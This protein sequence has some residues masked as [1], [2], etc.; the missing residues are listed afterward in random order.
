MCDNEKVKQAMNKA[1]TVF[2]AVSLCLL[3]A[4]TWAVQPA[5]NRGGATRIQVT[6]GS[7][8]SRPTPVKVTPAPMSSA[9]LEMHVL[10]TG[11]PPN[12]NNL[13]SIVYNGYRRSS[14]EPCGC[15][16][17]KLGG[18]DREATI[19]EA[20]TSAG[21]PMIKLDAGGYV[22]DLAAQSPTFR[23]ATKYLLGALAALDY[24]VFNVGATDIEIGRQF[25][26]NSLGA[27]KDRLISA[28]I[29]DLATSSPLFAPYRILDV[30]LRNGETVKIGVTGITRPRITIATFE[31][32]PKGYV[33]T[34][35][36]VALRKVLPELDKKCDIVILLAYL[37]REA[38]TNDVLSKLGEDAKVDIA[39]AGEFSGL[40]NA[41]ENASG[42]RLVTGGFEGRQI[43]HL[44][45]DIRNGKIAQDFLKMVEIEQTISPRPDISKFITNY[46]LELVKNDAGTSTPDP[47]LR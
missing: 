40:R 44:V 24:D 43:G 23:T 8:A 5:A 30:K 13:L 45:L 41:I 11:L 21:L 9:Q 10:P 27:K 35:P 33:V 18:I 7:M 36:V 46:L 16:S 26:E 1:T 42:I 31:Q 20:I 37:N 22:R 12:R 47:L 4:V 6:S 3:A 19:I 34:D 17:H 38:L 29:V 2:S 32:A 39:I 25:L 28:N 14:L 15:V